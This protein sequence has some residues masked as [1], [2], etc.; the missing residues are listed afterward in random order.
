VT[1][2]EVLKAVNIALGAA[3]VSTCPLADANGDGAVT[4]NEIVQAV[5]NALY[6]CGTGGAGG[7]AGSSGGCSV[8]LP[9]LAVGST[10]GGPGATVTV[11][12]SMS[13]SGNAAA[14]VQLD[15]LFTTSV[16]SLPNPSAA[17]AKPQVINTDTGQLEDDPRLAQHALR[18]AQPA[19][20]RLRLLV[21][22]LNGASD[23]LTDGALATCTFR[24]STTALA[25][26]YPLSPANVAA[27][28]AA[29]NALSTS[30]TAGAIVVPTPGPAPTPTPTPPTGC[31]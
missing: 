22:D 21:V 19:A 31:G 18:T 8:G 4:V 12:V 17:C 14:A 28:D 9:V 20:G 3:Q 24:L 7:A 29:G 16:L 1:V 15:V 11:P 27:S 30:G 5:N 13:N 10:L 23:L 2:D 6:N 25:G 26:S